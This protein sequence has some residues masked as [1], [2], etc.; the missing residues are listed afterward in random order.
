[1]PDVGLV[2]IVAFFVLLLLGVPIYL[3]LGMAAVTTI[4]LFDLVPLTAVPGT[5]RSSLNSF[6]LLAIPFFILAGNLLANSEIAIRLIDLARAFVG[7]IRGG[8]AVVSVWVGVFFAGISGSGPADVGAQGAVLIPALEKDGYPR[9][10]ASALI[11]ANGAIGIIV[12][13]SIGLIV[14]GVVANVSIGRL[15]IAGII[16]G[17]V[18]AMS[19]AF[20]SIFLARRHGWGPVPASPGPAIADADVA[21]D[22]PPVPGQAGTGAVGAPARLR[23]SPGERLRLLGTALRRATWGLLAPVIILGGIYG[24]VFTPTEAAAVVVVYALFVGMVIYRD[25]RFRD[26]PRIFIESARMSGVVMIIVASASLYAFLLNTEGIA[27]DFAT[28]LT[29]LSSNPI[30]LLLMINVVI[31]IAGTLLDAVSIYYIFVPILLPVAAVI[32]VDPVHF[33]LILTV[34]LALGQITP[35]VGVN[36]FVAASV[37]DVSVAE[38]S[39]AVLPILAAGIIALLILSFVPALTLWLPDLIGA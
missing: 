1:M 32:G 2:L 18:V 22:A 13:P 24:G 12:P 25:I 16:P 29:E 9:A 21:G 3:S 34:N 37:G 17:I 10:Y 20:V 6:T 19:F 26:L 28:A 8:L 7:A 15:F 36:L 5:I 35:P 39:R 4:V 11:A 14:Y 38:I 31:L 33:G 27:R 30:V 23:L